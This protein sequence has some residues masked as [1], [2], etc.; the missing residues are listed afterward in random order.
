MNNEYNYDILFYAFRY[1]L[2]RKTYAVNDVTGEII[3]QLK[4]IPD[5]DLFNMHKEIHN[6][7]NDEKVT[8]IIAEDI[9]KEWDYTNN[10]IIEELV[11]RGKIEISIIVNDK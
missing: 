6:Y 3:K 4:N 9:N 11:T 8:D 5:K 2:G 10:R 7:L 1:A